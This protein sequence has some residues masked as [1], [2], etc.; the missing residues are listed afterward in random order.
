MCIVIIKNTFWLG[1]K[2]S[3]IISDV[4]LNRVYLIQSLLYWKKGLW[5]FETR[6]NSTVCVDACIISV[7]ILDMVP[8]RSI[9]WRKVSQWRLRQ[10]VRKCLRH[11]PLSKDM[12]YVCWTIPDLYSKSYSH[13]VCN[14]GMMT[15]RILQKV[16]HFSGWNLVCTCS[17]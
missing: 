16:H 6:N 17:C 9:A 13:I 2:A 15:I 11:Q 5:Y 7:L 10:S 12:W 4:S 8:F 3:F 14:R 1:T